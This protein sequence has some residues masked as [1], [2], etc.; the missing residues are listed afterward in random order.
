MRF[1]RGQLIISFD[2][3]AHAR[4]AGASIC[5]LAGGITAMNEYGMT[6]A[7]HNTDFFSSSD[8]SGFIP[9]TMMVRRL[10]EQ[11]GPDWTPATL[12][13]ALDP[14]PDYFGANLH[15]TFPS[16]GRTDDQTAGVLEFDGDARQPAGRATL[17]SPSENPGL[18][19]YEAYDHSLGAT[20]ALINT[21][22]YV[23]RKPATGS[24]NNSGD[25]YLT[26]KNMLGD[27]QSDD[28]VTA[29]E[30]RSI[31]AAVGGVGTMHTVIFEPDARLFRMYLAEP[32][33]PAFDCQPH[34]YAFEELF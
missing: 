8:M 10:M 16:A 32:G 34:F 15:A 9:R 11:A 17:R 33:K 21:N 23:E 13:T 22:H 2:D 5:G 20:W 7:L 29:E 25:R 12:D 30:A 4:W 14:I 26:I 3:G 6:L 28:N 31:M 1:Q 27:A 19:V 24:V 18:P